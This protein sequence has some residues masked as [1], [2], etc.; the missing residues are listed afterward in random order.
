[1]A[2]V[3]LAEGIESVVEQGSSLSTTRCV[4]ALKLVEHLAQQTMPR[5]TV[6]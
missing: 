2:W 5:A 4:N 3:G 6:S 1:M